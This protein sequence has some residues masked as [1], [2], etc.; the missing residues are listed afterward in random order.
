[1]NVLSTYRKNPYFRAGVK[2]AGLSLAQ[3]LGRDFTKTAYKGTKALFKRR[4]PSYRRRS[5][6]QKPGAH[7]PK[8][9]KRTSRPRRKTTRVS[10]PL[11]RKIKKVIDSTNP[12][13]YFHEISVSSTTLLQNQQRV[14]EPNQQTTD[15]QAGWHFTPSQFLNAASV[16]WNNKSITANIGINDSNNFN[17]ETLQVYVKNSWYVCRI[18]NNSQHTVTVTPIV[19]QPKKIVGDTASVSWAAELANQLVIPTGE[20][21]GSNTINHLYIHPKFSSGMNRYW[22]FT[23]SKIVLE[24][25]QEY[26]YT[27]QGPSEKMLKF[28]NY[29][30][31]NIFKNNQPFASNIMF[32]IHGD[33]QSDANAD[34][35]RSVNSGVGAIL[36]ENSHHY[37]LEMPEQTGWHESGALPAVVASDLRRRATIFFNHTPDPVGAVTQ[38]DEDNPGVI[39]SPP[40]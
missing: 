23:T 9:L 4:K 39:I 12:N 32:L 17:N 28:A 30:D 18:K 7:R 14:F 21:P 40:I 3:S 13:G 19:C 16:L 31:G 2:A 38:I 27:C 10:R 1:M 35:V 36:F 26:R 37:S 34:P 22:K 20:N 8:V 6:K 11:R 33:L 5:Y 25:G 24:P 29:W 15:F